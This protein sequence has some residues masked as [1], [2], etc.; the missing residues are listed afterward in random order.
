MK[1]SASH[2]NSPHPHGDCGGQ[3]TCGKCIIKIS[4]TPA[5]PPTAQ[6]LKL[7]SRSQLAAGV[8]LACQ[9]GIAPDSW[10]ARERKPLSFDES[11]TIHEESPAVSAQSSS[12][13]GHTGIAVDLGT[14]TIAAYLINKETGAVDRTGGM[15][16]PQVRYGADVMSRILHSRQNGGEALQ[17]TGLGAISQLI[18]KLTLYPEQVREMTIV[19]NTVMHHLLLGLPASQ[20]GSFPFQPAI[21]DALAVRPEDLGLSIVPDALIYF[22]PN[23]SGFI[24]SDHLAMVCATDIYKTGKTVLGLDIGT[25]TEIVLAHRGLLKS[26]SCASGPAF[27]GCQIKHGMRALSGAID[28]MRMENSA[29]FVTTVDTAA[30]RGICGSGILAIA[31][32]LV[33]HGIISRRGHLTSAPGVRGQGRTAE[34]ELVPAER[35]ATGESITIT[36]HDIQEIQLAKAAIRAGCEMLLRDAGITWDYVEQVVLAGSF[37]NSLDVPA[38][39]TL[40][41]FPPLGEKLFTKAGNAAGAGAVR[42]LTEPW[43][44][45][46]AERIARRMQHVELA[47]HP[48]FS[49]TFVS[50]LSF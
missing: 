37:G 7:L 14:T 18:R 25:N 5:S 8:R 26:A 13:A 39:M 23:V 45:D 41:I 15:L 3:G 34:F 16:N 50:A 36:Q 6:E 29:V 2:D 47:T 46:E 38:A 12:A 1:H 27:E 20:L 9:T 35:S 30:P 4:G 33:R 42:M 22:L 19:G 24:G 28:T 32:E 44:R 11:I 49:S 10:S 17:R 40:G 43:L 21:K 48:L 31:A